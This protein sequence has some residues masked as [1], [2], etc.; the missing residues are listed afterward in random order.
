MSES[1]GRKFVQR[2]L[3]RRSTFSKVTFFVIR[4]FDEYCYNELMQFYDRMSATLT[5]CPVLVVIITN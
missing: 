4:K 5:N 2:L 1:F 3:N